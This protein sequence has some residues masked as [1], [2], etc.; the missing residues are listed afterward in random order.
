MIEIGGHNYKNDNE[1]HRIRSQDNFKIVSGRE[2][3]LFV[4][5]KNKF[6]FDAKLFGYLMKNKSKINLLLVFCLLSIGW[7]SSCKNKKPSILKVYVRSNS[8]ELIDSATVIVVGDQKSNPPTLAYVD[9]AIT[10]SSGYAE[11]NMQPYFDLAGEK[12]NPTG[13]FDIITKKNTK[14]GEGSVRCRVHI[15]AVETIYLSN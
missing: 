10:N 5:L 15:T 7:L 1:E 14:E 6:I 4:H 11:F 2:I 3:E 13:Y 8:N 12:D 9:T